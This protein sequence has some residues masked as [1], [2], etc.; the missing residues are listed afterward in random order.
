VNSADSEPLAD[1][2]R[3]LLKKEERERQAADAQRAV[4]RRRLGPMPAE[5][6]ALAVYNA[7]RWRGLV[8]TAEYDAAMARLQC[9]FNE[10]AGL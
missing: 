1:W 6:E 8:H 4:R 9:R 7:E 2:E 10:W 3:K 5:F